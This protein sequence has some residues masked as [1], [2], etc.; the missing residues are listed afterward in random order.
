MRR[1]AAEALP[2][3]SNSYAGRRCGWV[4]WAIC[5]LPTVLNAASHGLDQG[6]P[7]VV[8]LRQLRYFLK[9]ADLKSFSHAALAVHIAQ[10]ALSRQIRR[11]EEEVGVVLFHRDGRGALLTEEGQRYY[12]R[13]KGILRQLDQASVEMQA[14]RDMPTGE[15]VLGVP[16]QLGPVIRL[17]G[18]TRYVHFA[19]ARVEQ[20]S[21]PFD[22]NHVE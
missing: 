12:D 16:P 13:V 19:V 11:L 1:E 6:S 3:F 5:F 15:V 17:E 20:R 14:T 18:L 7:T 4:G 9:V 22:N 2:S 21:P 8:E 10:S